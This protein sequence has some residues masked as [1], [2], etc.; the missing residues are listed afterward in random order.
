MVVED[1][2]DTQNML[3]FL[4]EQYGAAVMS[5]SSSTEALRALTQQKPDILISDLGM[6]DMDGFELIRKIRSELSPDLQNL[7]AYANANAGFHARIAKPA[8]VDHLL[9][10]VAKL[11]HH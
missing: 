7:L 11:A 2:P 10:V 5:A 8:A 6:P 1:D 9:L 3:R 4:L